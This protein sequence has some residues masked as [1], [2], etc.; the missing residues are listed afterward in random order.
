LRV[1]GKRREKCKRDF[2]D[3]T[4]FAER[5]KVAECNADYCPKRIIAKS[6][7]RQCGRAEVGEASMR[8]WLKSLGLAAAALGICVTSASAQFGPPGGGMMPPPGGGMMGPPPGGGMM[9]P[10]PGAF[11]M[12]SM[13]P[14]GGMMAPGAFNGAPPMGAP[15]DFPNPAQPSQEPVSPFSMRDDGAPNAFTTLS[16]PYCNAARWQISAGY[17]LI[18]F[19]A[20][21]F[22][23]LVTTGSVNDAQ[24]AA[25]GQPGTIVLDDG[26]R[27]PGASAAFR[28]TFTYWLIDPEVMCLDGNFFVMEQRSVFR[29]FA[30]TS[31]GFPLLARPFFDPVNNVETSDVRA[32]PSA[33]A[34]TLSDG[35]RT[36]LMGAELN[37]KFFS[38]SSQSQG[39]VF[40]C[41]FGFRWLRLDEQY[42]SYDTAT[43]LTGGG[44]SSTIS[45]TFGTLNNFYGGQ[46][47]AEWMCRWGRANFGFIGK[48]AVGPIYQNIHISGMTTQTDSTTGI[49]I[50]DNQGLFAQP[51]NR[52][53]Y[54]AVTTSVLPEIG[55]RFS[56]DVN[57]HIRFHINYSY[58]WMY[59]TVRPGDTMDRNVNIQPLLSGGGFGPALPPPPSFNRSVFSAQ[60]LSFALEFVF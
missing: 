18:W 41:F 52:G 38:C 3:D 58:F 48:V 42:S 31:S 27:N 13:P 17:S 29:S 14:G 11:G 23:P 7:R 44:L 36:R 60:M 15:A 25:L 53:S 5:F 16:E 51:S 46:V 40:S 55:S 28:T 8:N 49:T 37:L 22:F 4:D 19:K 32:F 20:N 47:G 12:T 35:T 45:D 54:S 30:S 59:N 34:G 50:S 24:P 26:S 10:P 43:D 56:V 33:L 39:S 1:I 21:S 9:A 2:A 6:A 57:D